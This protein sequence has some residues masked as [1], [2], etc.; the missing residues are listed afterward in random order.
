M[1]KSILDEIIIETADDLADDL[2]HYS[3]LNEK[4]NVNI[5]EEEPDEDYDDDFDEDY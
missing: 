1:G 5:E 4:E 2:E 3:H